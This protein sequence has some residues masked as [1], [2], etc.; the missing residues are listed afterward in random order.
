[1]K[2]CRDKSLV[3]E[4]VVNHRLANGGKRANTMLEG[5]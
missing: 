1:M 2:E 5:D 4:L 3:M